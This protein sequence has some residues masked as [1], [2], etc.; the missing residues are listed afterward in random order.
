G[1]PAEV[2]ASTAAEH[3][4]ERSWLAM[5]TVDGAP[6]GDLAAHAPGVNP[7]LLDEG[8]AERRNERICPTLRGFLFADRIAARIVAAWQP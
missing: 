1:A 4:A 8:L 2:V 7:W 5:R 6:A 3:A